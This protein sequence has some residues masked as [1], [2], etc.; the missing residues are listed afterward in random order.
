MGVLT[1]KEIFEID[2]MS[3]F[4]KENILKNKVRK[5]LLKLKKE[6][7]EC[8]EKL[9]L[10]IIKDWGGIKGAKDIGTIELVNEFLKTKVAKFNRIASVSKIGSFMYPDEFAIYDSRVAYSLNWI[11]LSQ[12]AGNMYFPIPK[13]RNSKLN[14]FDMNV[15]IKLSNI[16]NYRPGKIE[17]ISKQK[18]I[19]NRNR[20]LYIEKNEAY[21]ELNSLIKKVNVKLWDGEKKKF[22]YN[23]E[24][25]L[26]AIADREI[27]LDIT[28]S[29]TLK[30]E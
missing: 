23:T 6:N 26:F 12:N 27:F 18:F 8:F 21:K 19:N 17:D 1:D 15:L 3:N 16:G 30:I 28:K 9:C 22:L 5:S 4:Q 25:L 24:M 11:I 20:L 2:Q 14:A 7:Q 10:W 13:S 29:V